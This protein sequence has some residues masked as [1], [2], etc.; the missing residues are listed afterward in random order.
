MGMTKRWIDD[1]Q[2]QAAKS[3]EIVQS[4]LASVG[5]WTSPEELMERQ[6]MESY[7]E[8]EPL[9]RFSADDVAEDF[10]IGF[11]NSFDP[12]T[13]YP[14]DVCDDDGDDF[15]PLGLDELWQPQDSSADGEALANAGFGTNEEDYG[16]C[17]DFENTGFGKDIF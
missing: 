11:G 10:L 4:Q 7:Y 15:E 16:W 1:L 3:D 14:L 2:E 8:Y 13:G 12:D 9:P 6:A 17:G 5:L